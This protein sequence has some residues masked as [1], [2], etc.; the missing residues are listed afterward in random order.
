M[1]YHH[2]TIEERGLIAQ[3]HKSRLSIRSIA[4]LLDRSPATISREL[5]RN[6]SSSKKRQGLPFAY[7]PWHAHCLAK[8]RRKNSHRTRMIH[9]TLQEYLERKLLET[10]SPDQIAHRTKDAPCMLPS[11]STIYRWIHQR[12]LPRVTMKQL[13]RK[14]R[15]KRPAE[16]RGRFNDQG[17]NI[18]KRPWEVYSRQT[19]GHWEGDTV[20]SGRVAHQRKSQACFVTLVERA[21]RYYLAI[22]V[23]NRKQETVTRAIIQELEPFA[24]DLVKTITFDRGKEFAGFKEIEEKLACNTY[25]CDPY[26][27][28][29]KGS[30]ENSNGLLREFYPKGMDLSLVDDHQ[31]QIHLQLMNNRPRKVLGYETPLEVLSRAGDC[32]CT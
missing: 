6:K 30:N 18:K 17:R 9:P 8:E 29:Q 21:S 27:A 31:L 14:G 13:R 20:E 15:F 25:F 2:L 28:W 26:C 16:T 23:P 22:P 4:T 32:C 7:F 12:I 10:W 19:L 1:S 5:R 11:C 3:Y 24:S